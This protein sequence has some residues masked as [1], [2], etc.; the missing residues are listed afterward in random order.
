MG[1]GKTIG[2]IAALVG[3]AA[4]SALF[5][6]T[7]SS[8]QP[9]AKDDLLGPA[10]AGKPAPAGGKGIIAGTLEPSLT[11]ERQNDAYVFTFT[12]KNQTERVQT[13]TFT[14]SKKYDYVLY[15]D[16]QKV[17]QFSEGKMFAQI[18]EERTLKQGEELSFQETFRGLEPGTY[19]L[20]WWLAD[21]NWPN[22]RATATFTVE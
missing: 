16:G 2:I 6:Y 10:P 8:D 11:Y 3:A 20:E 17:K 21:P 14:S 15:R 4:A 1:N 18:Y 9:Q 7:N 13:V 22:A 5:M 19:T 12:V